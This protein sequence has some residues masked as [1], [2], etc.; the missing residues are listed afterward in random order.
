MAQKSEYDVSE[1]EVY[2]HEYVVVGCGA[3]GFAVIKE[4]V[5]RNKRVFRRES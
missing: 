1:F 2:D 5:R 4:L 3:V